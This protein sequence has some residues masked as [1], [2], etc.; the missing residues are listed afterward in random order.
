LRHR[1]LQFPA[2]LLQLRQIDPPVDHGL[3]GGTD[4]DETP[5]RRRYGLVL[6]Q[7][8][9]RIP[10][11]TAADAVDFTRLTRTLVL[12][13]SRLKECGKVTRTRQRPKRTRKGSTPSTK[14]LP[15]SRKQ[16]AAMGERTYRANLFSRHRDVIAWAVVFANA[17]L[18]TLSSEEFRAR[19]DELLLLNVYSRKVL[20]TDLEREVIELHSEIREILAD[21]ASGD[22][23]HPN[24]QKD[25]P[26]LGNTARELAVSFQWS[27]AENRLYEGAVSA[28]CPERSPDASA[29]RADGEPRPFSPA[30]VPRL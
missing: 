30:D 25:L 3:A 8:A 20:W 5:E 19:C 12:Q 27:R 10:R 24:Y 2:H 15:D 11:D 21:L 6:R 13:S 7:V 1:D 18:D 23:A 14:P 4:A 28:R 9:G 17:D 16:R 26:A 29:R 22:P